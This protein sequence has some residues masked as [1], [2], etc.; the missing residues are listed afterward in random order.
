M[1][2]ELFYSVPAA[3]TYRQC[4][5]CPALLVFGKTKAGKP[6]PL[7]LTTLRPVIP[8]TATACGVPPGREAEAERDIRQL[9]ER[10]VCGWE[11]RTHYQTCP[12]AAEFGHGG[13][14]ADGPR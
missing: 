4:R 5:R 3:G 7:D 10:G 12:H 1:A 13:N 14:D 8:Q 9:L 6:V 11:A 2:G